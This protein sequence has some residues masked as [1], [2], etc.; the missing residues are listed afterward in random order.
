MKSNAGILNFI[1]QWC[2]KLW[3]AI[4][5]MNRRAYEFLSYTLVHIL[6]PIWDPG[7]SVSNLFQMSNGQ[8]RWFH[9][10]VM[11]IQTYVVCAIWTLDHLLNGRVSHWN[12]LYSAQTVSFMPN[13]LYPS[14]NASSSAEIIRLTIFN[15]L[16]NGM[17][18]GLIPFNNWH[19][20][21]SRKLCC[22]IPF[23]LLSLYSGQYP[24]LHA[25]N[26]SGSYTNR[27]YNI[28]CSLCKARQYFRIQMCLL[29]LAQKCLI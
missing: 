21:G 13:L 5:I 23:L 8:N 12:L 26:C 3:S 18:I 2:W 28:Q 24:Q 19:I 16:L 20:S 14:L 27:F 17:R 9:L 29:V 15:Y 22:A 4:H 7:Q 11:S 25:V 1:R 10:D 6:R